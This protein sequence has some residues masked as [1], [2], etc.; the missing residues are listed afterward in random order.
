MSLYQ[1][2]FE[3]SIKAVQRVAARLGL[4]AFRC[5]LILYWKI[6]AFFVPWVIMTRLNTL[7]VPQWKVRLLP[8]SSLALVFILGNFHFRLFI[9]VFGVYFEVVGLEFH[10]ERTGTGEKDFGHRDTCPCLSVPEPFSVAFVL[11]L[12]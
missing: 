3:N 11:F 10:C 6:N 9:F 4:F 12:F 1:F 2:G 5:I 8:L 7:L